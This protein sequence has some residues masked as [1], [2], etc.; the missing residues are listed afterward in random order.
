MQEQQSALLCWENTMED[1]VTFNKYLLKHSAKLRQRRKVGYVVLVLWIFG[2]YFA[3]YGTAHLMTALLY[4]I[5]TL[6]VCLVLGL[7][8]RILLFDRFLRKYYAGEK[9][10]GFIGDHEMELTEEGLIHRTAYTESKL[11]WGVIE[12]IESTKEHT[13]IFVGTN[14]AI[15][16]PHERITQGVYGVFMQ[17]LGRRF[18]PDQPLPR[19]FPS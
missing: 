10:R 18:K 11:A 16:I 1:M 2:C 14:A 3:L 17:E 9:N 5:G 7:G 6:G 12:R 15:I 13:F 4:S 8:L 19:Q